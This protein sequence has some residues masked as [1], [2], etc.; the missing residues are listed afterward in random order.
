MLYHP[1]VLERNKYLVKKSILAPF[2]VS[3]ES[4]SSTRCNNCVSV[5]RVFYRIIFISVITKGLCRSNYRAN[6]S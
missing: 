6:L 5:I 1:V 2:S 4:N 3:K